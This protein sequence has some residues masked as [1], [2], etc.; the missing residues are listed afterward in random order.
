MEESLYYAEVKLL[1]KYCHSCLDNKMK[2]RLML[3]L[4]KNTLYENAIELGLEDDAAMYYSE[5][6]N[7]LDMKNC[8]CSITNNTCTNGNCT[9]RK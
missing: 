7:L 8:N 9:I 4:M 1:T 3:F 5:M 6:L 2:E